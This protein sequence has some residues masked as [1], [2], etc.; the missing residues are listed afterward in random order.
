MKL[1]SRNATVWWVSFICSALLDR[2]N[3]SHSC[4]LRIAWAELEPGA[5]L[6]GVCIIALLPLA[7]PAN[8]GYGGEN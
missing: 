2:G 6:L 4:L 8:G 1:C 3:K 7:Q 5:S